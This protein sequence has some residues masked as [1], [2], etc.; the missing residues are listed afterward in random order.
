[1]VSHLSHH[2]GVTFEVD[3]GHRSPLAAS[4]QGLRHIINFVTFRTVRRHRKAS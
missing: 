4:P 2:F 3:E 1:M